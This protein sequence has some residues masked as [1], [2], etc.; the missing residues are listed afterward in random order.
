MKNRVVVIGGAGFLGSH[1]IELLLEQGYPVLCVDR[2]EARHEYIDSLGAD[3]QVGDVLDQQSIQS[4]LQEGDIVY[5]LAA[6]L[7]KAPVTEEEYYGLNVG[8]VENV[9]KAAI[10]AGASKFVFPSSMAAVG[11]VGSES[12][13]ITENSVCKPRTLYGKTKLLAENKIKELAEGK[14]TVIIFRPPPFFGPR[15][16]PI[17]AASVLFKKMETPTLVI[18]GNQKNFFPLCFV[19]NLAWA[20]VKLME[21][22]DSGIN[23]Y[24]ISDDDP[25][26]LREILMILRE[27]IGK[28]RR[29]IPLP[30]WFAYFIA[31]LFE[32]AGKVL[33]F[34]PQLTTDIVDGIA[35]SFYYHDIS[36]AKADGY[37]PRYS[38][39]EGVR[40]TVSS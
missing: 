6:Y 25:V 13:P 27:E 21:N 10:I 33:R 11:P 23:M 24:V 36:K 19:G 40:I 28:N 20:M 30:Y 38:L 29:I 32:L 2:K 12:Q 1:L 31:S 18:I 16:N 14:I 15:A 37:I 7:G 22:N 34:E 5:H 8:G 9:L 35:R 26:T 17:T 39:Q 3:F 4:I